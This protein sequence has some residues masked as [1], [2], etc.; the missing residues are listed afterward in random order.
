MEEGALMIHNSLNDGSAFT[1]F[2]DMVEAQGGNRDD[3]ASDHAML[4]SLG[5]LGDDLLQPRFTLRK[6]DGLTILMRCQ[7]H[8]PVSNWARVGKL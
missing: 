2:L 5:L 3:F 1:K 6:K 4:S 7:L 8:S